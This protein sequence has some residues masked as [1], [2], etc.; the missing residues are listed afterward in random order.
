[1]M[2][3][4]YLGATQTNAL[5]RAGAQRIGI[6]DTRLKVGRT[7]QILRMAWGGPEIE[8]HPPEKSKPPLIAWA[9]TES[10]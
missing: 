7:Q 1:M 8:L 10:G 9:S 2:T 5:R 4:V 3:G 6:N